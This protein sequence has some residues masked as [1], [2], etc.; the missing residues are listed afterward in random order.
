[1]MKAAMNNMVKRIVSVI[2]MIVMTAAM[3]AYLPAVNAAEEPD[4]EAMANEIAVLINEA[5]EAAGLA[6]IYILPYLS[7]IAENQAFEA[8]LDYD[9]GRRD[10]AHVASSID[11]SIVNYRKA[12][13]NSAVGTATAEETLEMW[14]ADSKKWALIMNK[15]IT[16]MGIAVVYDEDTEFGWYWQQAMVAT[17][18]TFAEQY[19]PEGENEAAPVIAGDINNDGMVNMYDYLTLVSYLNQAHNGKQIVFTDAQLEAA[20]CF[21][22]GIISEADA[23]IIAKYILGEVTSLPYQF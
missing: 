15:D 4:T 1:M 19:L 8:A 17:N 13:G 23:K 21:K 2:A 16:H 9:G 18:M 3:A 14:K 11:K 7:E 22:D 20:D 5:R 10:S 12:A 6:P